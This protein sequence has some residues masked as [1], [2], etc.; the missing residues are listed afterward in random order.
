[1]TIDTIQVSGSTYAITTADLGGLKV[2][3][4]TQ[5]AYD[6]L[7]TKDNNTLYVITN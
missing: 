5:S 4:I 3:K 1:M 2:E 6:A 7:V